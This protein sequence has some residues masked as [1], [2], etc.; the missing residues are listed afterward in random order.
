MKYKNLVISIFLVFAIG[1]IFNK[2]KLNIEKDDKLDEL[3]LIKKYL[4]NNDDNLDINNSLNLIK[5]P[6]LWIHID[7]EK[8]SRNWLS[9]YS[10]ST[11]DYNQDYIYLTIKS[12]IDKCN[13]D[14][15]IIIIDDDSFKMLL[16]TWKVDFS[17]LANPLKTNMRILGIAKLLY[18]YGGIYLENS[19][20]L[21]KSLKPIYDKILKD[22]KLITAEFKN[23]SSESNTVLY[24]PSWKF[25]GCQKNCNLMQQFVQ[26]LE[27]LF[28]NDFTNNHLVENTINKFLLSCTNNGEVNYIDGKFIGVKD[29][30]NKPITI[31]QLVSSN[32][33]DLDLNSYA[34]YIPRDE[35]LKR[36]CYNWF[37]Y[38]KPEEVLQQNTNISKYLLL[39]Q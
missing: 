31:D 23:T 10:R 30:N 29:I 1:Y 32:F 2:F 12:I 21:F 39:A 20:I 28:S 13:Q 18:N 3:N 25:L 22:K 11:F 6:I 9:F 27:I 37:V 15:H 33:L 36:N 7:Y 17:K 4:L 19:F 16:P 38:L 5:K 24:M 35:L 26:N 14:F 34:L 8:N